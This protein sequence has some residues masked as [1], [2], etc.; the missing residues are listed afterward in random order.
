LPNIS[1]KESFPGAV[2]SGKVERQTEDWK[3]MVDPFAHTQNPYAS[4]GGPVEPSAPAAASRNT[5]NM[6]LVE[7]LFLSG[8]LT[9]EDYYCGIHLGRRGL[10]QISA[11]VLIGVPLLALVWLMLPA[12]ARGNFNFAAFDSLFVIVAIAAVYLVGLRWI[13]RS[14]L[15][16]I[17][18]TGKGA[19]AFT[20]STMY[21]D[22]YEVRQESIV[23]QI[24]WSLFN[25]YR[26]CDRLVVLF[27]EG[28]PFQFGIIPRSKFRSDHDW[29]CFI[30]LLDRKMP[31]C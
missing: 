19:F 11:F 30:G 18:A 20:E 25:K 22:H 15:R 26:Y 10:R 24:K 6:P 16:R 3:K 17:Q 4:P 5:P 1:K 12:I 7:P 2:R 29:Q 27:Y 8:Q 14:R 21:E 9:L 31:R 28:S 23:S 13:L